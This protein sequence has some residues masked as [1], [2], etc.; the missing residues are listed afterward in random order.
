MSLKLI[1]FLTSYTSLNL[2]IQTSK[3]FFSLMVTRIKY[4]L[5]SRPFFWPS[6]P[7]VHWILEALSSQVMLPGLKLDHSPPTNADTQMYITG[8]STCSQLVHFGNLNPFLNFL[9]SDITS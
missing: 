9:S 7:P 4:F 2:Y 5:S 6:E 8:G 3:L 1:H